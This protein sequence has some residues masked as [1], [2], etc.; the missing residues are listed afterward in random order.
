MCSDKIQLELDDSIEIRNKNKTKNFFMI[1]FKIQ[2][3]GKFERA[4]KKRFVCKARK[5]VIGFA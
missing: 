4:V 2:N 5:S 1:T 3:V